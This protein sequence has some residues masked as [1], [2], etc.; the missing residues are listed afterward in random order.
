MKKQFKER[1]FPVLT[2]LAVDPAHPFPYISGLSLNL[3]VL[4]R[5]DAAQAAAALHDYRERHADNALALDKWFAVQA[6]LPGE[7]ALDRVRA[8]EHDAAFTLKNPN[9]VQS[10]LGA[11]VRSN[12]SGFHRLDGAGYRLLA[13]R[14]MALDALNPQV[15]AR[16]ATAFN[17]WQRLEPQRREAAR[18][19]IVELAGHRG[20]SRNLAEI[21]GSVLNH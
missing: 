8:L 13:E 19:A 20:L 10:L 7:P 15:A 5:N 6:Q 16:L 18:A 4:V 1:L 17:G 2:P 9:R 11:F 14:L 3:A 21:V 12:P